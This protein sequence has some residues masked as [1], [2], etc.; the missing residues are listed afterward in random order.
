MRKILLAGDFRG[1]PKLLGA[2][3][4]Y[5]LIH[6]HSFDSLQAEW[7]RGGV[8]GFFFAVPDLTPQHMEFLQ[9]WKEVDPGLKWVFALTH[10]RSILSSLPS[11]SLMILQGASLT[12]GG[13]PLRRWLDGADFRER[14][15]ERMNCRGGIRV[16]KSAYGREET[17]E[18]RLE[19]TLENLSRQGA[20]MKLQG[21]LP[22]GDK[23]FVEIAYVDSRGVTVRLHSQVRWTRKG[24]AGDVQ[25]GVQFLA[26]AA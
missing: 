13:G 14:A 25:I 10:P 16:K 1:L 6:C 12:R 5:Q 17:A 8:L 21:D 11:D 2:L 18:F 3:N 24:K 7:K 20:Q 19:G 9:K 15:F 23:D 22:F 26:Q 4:G